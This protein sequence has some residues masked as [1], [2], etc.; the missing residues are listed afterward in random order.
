MRFFFG[1]AIGRRQVSRDARKAAEVLGNHRRRPEF[2]KLGFQIGMLSR[3]FRKIRHPTVARR[4]NQSFEQ[5]KQ[6]FVAVVVHVVSMV[7]QDSLNR[8]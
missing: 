8:K 6:Q 4:G 5:G 7:D 1:T 3:D 2:A